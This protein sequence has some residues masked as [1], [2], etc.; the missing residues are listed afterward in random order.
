[1]S[2]I[3]SARLNGHEPFAYLKDVLE[4]LP[5][6]PYSKIGEVL[7]HRWQPTLLRLSETAKRV[8]REL[9][10]DRLIFDTTKPDGALRKLMD[11]GLLPHLGWQA[12]IALPEGFRETY[13]WF[14]INRVT[15]QS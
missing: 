8:R 6:Q 15:A 7:P 13:T 2:P 3:Q 11:V 5:T 9:T 4:R 12:R 14:R 10:E 1:M